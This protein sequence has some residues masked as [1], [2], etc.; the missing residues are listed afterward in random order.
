M[1]RRNKDWGH[2][3]RGTSFGTNT[4]ICWVY[5]KICKPFIST[6]RVLSHGIINL[7]KPEDWRLLLE[8]IRNCTLWDKILIVSERKWLSTGKNNHSAT[9]IQT[10]LHISYL[11]EMYLRLRQ[12]LCLSLERPTWTRNLVPVKEL[13]HLADYWGFR[14][15]GHLI[16]YLLS[17]LVWVHSHFGDP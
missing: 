1:Q 9:E 16:F 15:K 7:L 10:P 11:H 17:L 8:M 2:Q 14:K 13:G 6:V 4:Y 3:S 5:G 12:L